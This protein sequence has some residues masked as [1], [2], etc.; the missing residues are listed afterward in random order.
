MPIKKR[1]VQ[2]HHIIYNNP[3]KRQ[4]EI[5]VPIWRSEH[6][7]LMRLQRYKYVTFGFIVS[8]IF[9]LFRLSV[10]KLLPYMEKDAE[11]K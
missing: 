8:I 7:A 6:W 9:E 5:I 3:E 2:H 11:V 10:I 4:G 1:V